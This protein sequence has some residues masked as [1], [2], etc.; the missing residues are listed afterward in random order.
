MLASTEFILPR[1][2]CDLDGHRIIELRFPSGLTDPSRAILA[3]PGYAATGESFAR[4]RPLATEHDLRLLTMLTSDSQGEIIETY[5]RTVAAFTRRFDRPVL[6]ATSFGGLV[7][8]AAARRLG[9][10]LAGLILISSFAHLDSWG[11]RLLARS[12]L[13][14]PL[15]RLAPL[16]PPTA[17]RL[18]AGGR[19][20]RAAAAELERE[21]AQI[22]PR[23][24]HR[25][26]VAAIEADLRDLAVRIEVPTLVIHGSADRLVPLNAAHTLVSCFHEA[27]LRV[28]P[29]AG[30][31]PYLTHPEEVNRLVAEFLDDA[32]E[33]RR[34]AS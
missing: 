14:G 30:H 31:V 15:Q 12:G 29:G 3:I 1:R 7:A 5:A 34:A 28:I 18:L 25:R 20:D 10:H 11:A 21:S 33:S 26:L 27:R 19:L 17:L 32:A 2:V 4:L 23:E 16:I 22:D 24:K 9:D 13:L 8:I 6:A